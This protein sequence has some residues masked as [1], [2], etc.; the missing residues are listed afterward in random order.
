ML[1]PFSSLKRDSSKHCI[2]GWMDVMDV[3]LAAFA[4]EAPS[5]GQFELY[6]LFKYNIHIKL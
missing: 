3:A 6:C 1:R 5:F 4:I 2:G